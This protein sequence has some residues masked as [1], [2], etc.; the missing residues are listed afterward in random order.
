MKYV[1]LICSYGDGET[2]FGHRYC[3][4]SFDT[5]TAAELAREWV[6]RTSKDTRCIIIPDGR[7]HQ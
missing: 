7:R 4:M 6:L 5:E 1:L 2:S 3:S